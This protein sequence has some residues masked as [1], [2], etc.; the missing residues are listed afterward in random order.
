VQVRAPGEQGDLFDI[1]QNPGQTP[2]DC[3]AASFANLTRAI[4]GELVVYDAP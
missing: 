1:D 3:A 2:P 4:G